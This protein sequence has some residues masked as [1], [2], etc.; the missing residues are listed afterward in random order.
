M[1]WPVR[2]LNDSPSTM[3]ALLLRMHLGTAAWVGRT[4]HRAAPFA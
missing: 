2:E 1:F 3:P 4:D